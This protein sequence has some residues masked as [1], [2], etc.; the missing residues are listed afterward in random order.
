M[1]RISLAQQ[2]AAVAIT[3]AATVEVIISKEHHS[4][5]IQNAGNE[6]VY[7]GGSDV[8]SANGRVLYS[9]DTKIFTNVEVTFSIYFVVAATKTSELR[10]VEYK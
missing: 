5:E 8:T 7:F 3:D 10:I 2:R 6:D 4:I 9:G 1:A